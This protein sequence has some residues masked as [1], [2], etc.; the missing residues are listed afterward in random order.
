MSSGWVG[1]ENWS[2]GRLRLVMVAL[3]GARV[4]TVQITLINTWLE[5]RYLVPEGRDYVFCGDKALEA[6]TGTGLIL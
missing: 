4:W 2:L 3:R 5:V 6:F 1:S